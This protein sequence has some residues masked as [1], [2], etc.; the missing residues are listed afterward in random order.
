MADNSAK[1]A[2]LR[3]LYAK[4]QIGEQMFK[5][6]VS[7]LMTLKSD[8]RPLREATADTLSSLRD[9]VA[10]KGGSVVNLSDELRIAEPGMAAISGRPSMVNSMAKEGSKIE[11]TSLGRLNGKFGKTLKALGIAGPAISAMTMSDKVMAGEYGAAG[12]E[13]L[14]AAT[15]YLPVVGEVKAAIEPSELGN[16]ELPE[17]IMA[18]RALYNEQARNGG[19][20][21]E[22]EQLRKRYNFL[23][24]MK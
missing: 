20:K 10:D 18:E 13:G 16:S 2:I 14:D 6:N 7:Q 8:M 5:D 21:S 11:G 23:N 17:E 22:E 1:I 15:D 3:D 9:T 19:A 4:G 12:L 24:T